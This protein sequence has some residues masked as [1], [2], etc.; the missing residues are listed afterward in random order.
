MLTCYSSVDRFNQ[1]LLL[2]ILVGVLV[3]KCD[4]KNDFKEK[5]KAK[6]NM[7]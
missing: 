7:L 1:R 4:G 3:I 6:S 5:N 2:F